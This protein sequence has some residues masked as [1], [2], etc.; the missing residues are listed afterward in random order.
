[1]QQRYKVAPPQVLADSELAD[2]RNAG[3][4]PRELGQRFTA[5]ALDV[6][7]D[8][9]GKCFAVARKRPVGYWAVPRCWARWP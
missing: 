4:D 5:A 9:E 6:A 3:A 1:M 2:T 7:A 8:I